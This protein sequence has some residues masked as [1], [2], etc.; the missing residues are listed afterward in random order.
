M[1][2]NKPTVYRITFCL[3]VGRTVL[4]IPLFIRAGFWMVPN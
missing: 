3:D 4:Y 2:H 1:Q